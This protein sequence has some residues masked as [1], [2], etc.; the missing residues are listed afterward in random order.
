[1]DTGIR[2][3][4]TI[5][6]LLI[7]FVVVQSLSC[8][9]LF[10]TPWTAA[11]QASLSFTVSWSLLKLMSIESVMPCNHLILCCPL[12]LLPSFFP[13]IRV[14]S[15]ESV[16]PIRWSRYWS[17]SFSISP[18]NEYW[19]PLELIDLIFLPKDSQESSSAPQFG[20]LQ[21]KIK[22]L[23]KYRLPEKARNTGLFHSLMLKLFM[24]ILLCPL[25]QCQH[26]SIWL[27]FNSNHDHRG[28]PWWLRW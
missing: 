15:K 17:F 11:C 7:G 8:V 28:F 3:P 23:K 4:E 18:S 21:C 2:V 1:M 22:S 6:T 19:F 12:L 13:S 10:V 9:W 20:L 5:T 27:R 24:W 16:L 26:W 25:L 14:F